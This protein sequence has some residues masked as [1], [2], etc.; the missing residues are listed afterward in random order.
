MF[1]QNEACRGG[2]WEL[3]RKMLSTGS[4]WILKPRTCWKW[5]MHIW[6]SFFQSPTVLLTKLPQGRQAQMCCYWWG[7]QK[8]RHLLAQLKRKQR[9]GKWESRCRRILHLLI[10]GHSKH[11]EWS[12]FL[13][14]L[15][16]IPALHLYLT[17]QTPLHTAF[18]KVLPFSGLVR[19]A[20]AFCKQAA[21]TWS[22][23]DLLNTL[24][25]S[26]HL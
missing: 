22:R 18:T 5:P 20:V 11:K 24:C 2:L 8:E 9:R 17:L 19:S 23:A 26:C 14:N 13:P 12:L 25:G 16:A 10:G 1:S 21:M 6:S 3:W 15:E 4:R 7:Y